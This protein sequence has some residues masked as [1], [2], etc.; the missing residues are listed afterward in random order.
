LW[1]R[2]TDAAMIDDGQMAEIVTAEEA[3]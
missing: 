2:S 3:P 1:L